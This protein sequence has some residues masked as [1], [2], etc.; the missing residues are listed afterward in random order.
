MGDLVRQDATPRSAP[1]ILALLPSHNEEALLPAALRSLEAQTVPVERIVVV[2]DHSTDGTAAI[3]AGWGGRVGLFETRA[4]RDRKAGALNQALAALLPTLE[5]EDRVFV[6]D[7][8]STI[9]PDFLAHDAHGLWQRLQA[10]EYVRYAREIARDQAR[11]RVLTGTAT[12]VRVGA[13]RAVARA[14][15]ARQLP[16]TGIYQTG[17][18]CED[19]ELTLALKTLGNRCLSPQ[20]CVVHTEVMPTLGTWWR[21]RTRWQRG[22]LQ[23]LGAYGR[24]ATTRPYVLR[25]AVTALGIL[26]QGLLSLV[27]GW[28]LATG[29]LHFQPFWAA[30]GLVFVAERLTSV[31]RAGP[32]GRAIA[33]A[34]VPEMLYDLLLSA[35]IVGVYAQVV[36]R[37][38]GHWGLATIDRAR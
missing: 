26:M 5:D 33:A 23:C 29:T 10:S 17:A 25:Q 13:L 7:A 18:L 19:F 9:G 6:L 24:S 30:L 28:A 15:R 35:V 3:A 21:Q 31:W 1:R 16:G 11:A 34:V 38:E 2:S 32:T 36:L 8:D 20:A 12:V 37:R 4:N 22:A 27:T 14:R